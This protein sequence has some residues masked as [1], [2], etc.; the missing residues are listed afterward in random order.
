M[1]LHCCLSNSLFWTRLVAY[2]HLSEL[3]APERS[4]Q[5][6]YKLFNLVFLASRVGS[7]D[8]YGT[9]TEIRQWKH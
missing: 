2:L 3:G 4:I 1:L 7:T 5:F 9:I 6:L 8:I